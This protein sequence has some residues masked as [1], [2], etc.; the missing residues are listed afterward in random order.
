MTL[1]RV[2]CTLQRSEYKTKRTYHNWR[3]NRRL[4]QHVAANFWMTTTPDG[5]SLN[6]PLIFLPNSLRKSNLNRKGI[7]VNGHLIM[8][9]ILEARLHWVTLTVGQF[10]RIVKGY[11]AF[12]ESFVIWH[13]HWCCI[14]NAAQSLFMIWYCYWHLIICQNSTVATSRNWRKTKTGKNHKTKTKQWQL[15]RYYRTTLT[16]DIILFKIWQHWRQSPFLF[17]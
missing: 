15:G 6:W 2:I 13:V 16:S 8:W 12:N 9:V 4:G 7:D 3:L 11:N 1:C 14:Y 10:A 17:S 5:T